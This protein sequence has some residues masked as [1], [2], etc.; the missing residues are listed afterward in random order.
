MIGNHI[1][2]SHPAFRF[3]FIL[4]GYNGNFPLVFLVFWK[5]SMGNIMLPLYRVPEIKTSRGEITNGGDV[6]TERWK[7]SDI[8]VLSGQRQFPFQQ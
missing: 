1:R 8:I 4:S 7:L 3:I 2:F 6:I 5:F